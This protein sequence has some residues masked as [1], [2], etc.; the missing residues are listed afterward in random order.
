M[1]AQSISPEGAERDVTPWARLARDRMLMGFIVAMTFAH[2]VLLVFVNW[3]GQKALVG[4]RAAGRLRRIEDLASAGSWDAFIERVFFHGWPGEWLFFMPAYLMGGLTLVVIQNVI[5]FLVGLFFLYRLCESYFSRTVT[6][7]ACLSYCLLPGTLFHPQQLV[8]EAFCDPL[9][10]VAVYLSARMISDGAPRWRDALVLGALLSV[11]A[12]VRQVYLLFP[13]ILAGLML[14]RTA[15]LK[16][17]GTVADRLGDFLRLPAPRTLAVLAGMLVVAFSV[18]VGWR[19]IDNSVGAQYERDE[20]YSH[21]LTMHLYR[22]AERISHVSDRPLPESLQDRHTMS[23]GEF[24]G[25]A[26]GEP[27]G[28][29]W[30]LASDGI[31]L[32]AN[33]GVT[34]LLGRFMGVFDLQ[35]QGAAVHKW[36]DIRDEQGTLAMVQEIWRVSPVALMANGAFFALWLGFLVIALYGVWILLTTAMLSL[37]LRLLLILTPLYFLTFTFTAFSVRWDHRSPAEFILALFFGIGLVAARDRFQ[38]WRDARAAT[39]AA[40]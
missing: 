40:G 20:A 7:F 10:I 14:L 15:S 28:F 36:R 6:F 39:P 19:L 30:T 5:L 35:D 24:L 11:L 33:P 32:I 18:P 23:P 4:D 25:Y 29:V 21:G 12:F 16:R 8:T 37:P 13:L 3:G 22:R 17:D 2:T 26:V 27:K 34:M 1:T 31:N 9:L 38:A